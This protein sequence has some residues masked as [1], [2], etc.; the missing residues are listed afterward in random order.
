M[1]TQQPPKK[2]SLSHLS[3][4]LM[5]AGIYEVTKDIVAAVKAKSTDAEIDAVVAKSVAAYLARVE[6]G[7]L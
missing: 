5:Y 6:G 3:D 2:P 1:N 7:E 4:D